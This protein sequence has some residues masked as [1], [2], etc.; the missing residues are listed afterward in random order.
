MAHLLDT[1]RRPRSTES[2]ATKAA[3]RAT[4]AASFQRAG[5]DYAPIR[6]IHDQP[7]TFSLR[8]RQRPPW[9]WAHLPRS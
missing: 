2:R 3:K 7:A 1:P 6:I 9:S 8:S 4:A 5:F